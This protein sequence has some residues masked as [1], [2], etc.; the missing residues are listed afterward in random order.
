M[1]PGLFSLKNRVILVAGG[2]GY[3]GRAIAAGLAEHDAH[4]FVLG[5]SK[6]KFK[7]AFR[8]SD[9]IQFEECDVA[10]T[11]SVESALAGVLDRA[12]R[13][14]VLINNA[15]FSR[16]NDPELMSDE[17]W[18]HSIEGTLG[19]VHRGVRAALPY[20]AKEGKGKIINVSS[21][22]GVVAPNFGNYKDLPE[23]RSSAAYGAAKAAVIQ[24][25]RY[26]AA[27]LG[28]RNV[29]VNCVTPGAFPNE[30]AQAN[31]TFTDKLASSTPLGR[32]GR[33]DDLKGAFVFLSSEASDYVT[34]HN[35]VV[36]GGWTAW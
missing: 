16:G 31:K 3:L 7:A 23:Q 9:S 24:L 30:R 11:E 12:G 5:K 4:V 29:N 28:P 20:F 36:D 19:T 1:T 2:Y 35:L 14:D 18:S 10:S 15:F 34:G 8:H 33:P 13:I 26:Y 17:D 27:Y 21:M 22:Y 32:I 6:E 25:T